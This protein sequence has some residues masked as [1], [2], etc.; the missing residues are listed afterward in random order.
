[1]VGL[2]LLVGAVLHGS[3][4]AQADTSRA[5]RD[6]T[7]RD[8]AALRVPARPTA[9]SLLRDSLARRDSLRGAALRRDTL[10]TPFTRAPAPVPIEIGQTLIYDRAALFAS[11]AI[12]LQDLLD[13]VPGITGFRAGWIAAPMTSAFMGDVR[14][15][16]VFFDGVEYDAIDPRAA[17]QLDLT[18]VPLWPLEELRIERGATEVR[19]YAR[20]WRVDRTTPYSRTDISTGDEQTNLYRGFFGERWHQGE[21]LQLAAQ[22]YGTT[23]PFRGDPSSDQ[24]SLLGRLGWA[25]GRF[26][27]DG[28]ALRTN[29]NRGTIIPHPLRDVPVLDS[30]PALVSSRSDAYLRAGWGDPEQGPWLQGIASALV[31]T[32]SHK[33][34]GAF[35][36]TTNSSVPDTARFEAQY[37]VSGGLTLGALRLSAAERLRMVPHSFDAPVFRSGKGQELATP[38][39]RAELVTGPLAFSAFGEGRGPD[40]LARVEA[41][42][43]LTPLPFVSFLASAGH[44]TD[45]HAVDSTSTVNFLRGEA[46]IRLFDLWFIGGIMRRDST[47]LPAPTL[48]SGPYIAVASPPATGFTAAIRGTLYQALNADVEAIRWNDSAGFYRPRYETRSQIYLATNW[49]SRFP[50]GNFG[51]LVSLTHEYRS[52]TFFPIESNGSPTVVSVPDWRVYNFQI[53]FRLLSAILSYQFRNLIGYPYQTVPGLL[54]PRQT[55]FYGVRWEFWN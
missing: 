29:R 4:S 49:L 53:E 38:S 11:G 41:M 8:T 21:G 45:H 39:A 32:I 20:T 47:L 6:S 52:R 37:V 35:G 5:R 40:S 33:N 14:R 10:K 48:F 7:K 18:E 22:Q 15:V 50:S 24:L 26:S 44:S 36:T 54:M 3:A 13:R 19:V 43:R 23:P 9:D 55:Q 30:V 51:V 31:Y 27:V 2:G 28:F 25:R 42:A 17:R 46:G 1:M 12:T 16:R 34:T